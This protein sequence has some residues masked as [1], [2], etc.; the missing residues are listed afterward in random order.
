MIQHY[1]INMRCDTMS[2]RSNPCDMIQ[3]ADNMIWPAKMLAIK[4]QHGDHTMWY[5]T[6]QLRYNMFKMWYD[7]MPL[8][9]RTYCDRKFPA[10]MLALDSTQSDVERS[11]ATPSVSW[12]FYE[13]VGAGKSLCHGKLGV[14]ESAD[15]P[16]PSPLLIDVHTP[17]VPAHVKVRVRT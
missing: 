14:A 2:M 3:C 1:A 17:W 11:V 8:L 9:L 13:V 15:A 12:G 7:T 6:V 5:D 16:L 10:C 4:M